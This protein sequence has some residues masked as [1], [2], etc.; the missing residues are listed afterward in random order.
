MC[1]EVDMGRRR[2]SSDVLPKIFV[3]T[4]MKIQDD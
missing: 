4:D 2:R 1:S 3:L